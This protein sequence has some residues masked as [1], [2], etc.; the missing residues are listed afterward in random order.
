M[1]G[2]ADK[3]SFCR[4]LGFIVSQ[5]GDAAMH[6][7]SLAGSGWAFRRAGVLC[8]VFFGWIQDALDNVRGAPFDLII[9]VGQVGAD[10]AQAQQLD[11]AEEEKEDEQGREPARRQVREEDARNQDRK[12]TRLNSS[13]L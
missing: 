4:K 13:H 12:S 1:A 6:N 5:R 10:D 7:L 11:A 8:S 2:G 3:T 9:N